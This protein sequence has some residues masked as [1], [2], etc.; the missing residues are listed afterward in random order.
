[1]FGT[2]FGWVIDTLPLILGSTQNLMATGLSSL[3][4]FDFTKTALHKNFLRY[5]KNLSGLP[6]TDWPHS[7]PLQHKKIYRPKEMR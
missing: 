2:L 1:V 7:N 6:V 4:F 3:S 5:P